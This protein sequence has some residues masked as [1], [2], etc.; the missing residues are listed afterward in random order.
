MSISSSSN[1]SILETFDIFISPETYFWKDIK[2]KSRMKFK[3]IGSWALVS[4][5]LLTQYHVVILNLKATGHHCIRKNIMRRA[6]LK[7]FLVTFLQHF[8][9]YLF[10]HLEKLLR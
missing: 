4:L 6:Q 3:D 5:R 7:S 9:V 1:Q 2:L 8:S 10:I